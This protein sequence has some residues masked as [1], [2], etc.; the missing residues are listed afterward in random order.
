MKPRPRSDAVAFVRMENFILITIKSFHYCIISTY[1]YA[2][3]ASFLG[4]IQNKEG[5]KKCKNEQITEIKYKH[6]LITQ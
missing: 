1:Y 4:A 2:T 6:C 3:K 5:N